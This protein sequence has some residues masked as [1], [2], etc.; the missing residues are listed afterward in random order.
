MLGLGL[1]I[2]LKV[3]A[4]TK[5]E[6]ADAQLAELVKTTPNTYS[7]CGPNQFQPN[8]AGCARLTD[9]LASQDARN[10]GA[11]FGF[12]LAGI[13]AVGTAGLI[14]LPKFPAGRK[15]MTGMK[16]TPVIGLDRMGGTITGSF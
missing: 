13:G 12:V 11:V 3:S 1:G 15:M 9:T 6:E 5:G 16:I 10:N 14:L 2:G 7:V 8:A 4:G